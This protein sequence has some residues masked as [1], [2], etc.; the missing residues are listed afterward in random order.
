MEKSKN[1]SE[2]E[3]ITDQINDKKIIN[4]DEK[5]KEKEEDKKNEINYFTFD[6]EKAIFFYKF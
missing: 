3:K 2:K 4:S 5:G 1:F 6:K